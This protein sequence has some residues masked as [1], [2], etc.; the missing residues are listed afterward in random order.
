MYWLC[1]WRENFQQFLNKGNHDSSDM[2][3]TGYYISDNRLVLDNNHDYDSW[4]Y[5]EGE[6]QGAERI[7]KAV[8]SLVKDEIGI[9][10]FINAYECIK[11]EEKHLLNRYTTEGLKLAGLT[12]KDINVMEFEKEYDNIVEKVV[13]G[14][15]LI[16][17]LSEDKNRI[18]SVVEVIEV[19]KFYEEKHKQIYNAILELYKE[20]K[21]IEVNSV[22]AKLEEKEE[23]E[24]I[25]GLEYLVDLVEIAETENNNKFKSYIE[26]I[27]NR[28]ITI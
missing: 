8:S 13:I 21:R 6:L 5:F 14:K 26:S 25:G 4:E 24:N 11:N 12:T 9:D 2:Q 10:L 18:K 7:L 1:T 27:K 28:T 23:L 20:S 19:E 15:V 17:E 22:K 3:G 16:G